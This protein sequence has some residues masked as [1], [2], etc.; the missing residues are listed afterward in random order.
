MVPLDAGTLVSTSRLQVVEQAARA[1]TIR[2]GESI[3]RARRVRTSD[4]LKV[5]KASRPSEGRGEDFWLE[6]LEPLN[7]RSR[8]QTA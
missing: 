6:S 8:Y 7:R 2:N 1:F 5:V 3:D 4:R